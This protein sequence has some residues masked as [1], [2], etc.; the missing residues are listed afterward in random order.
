MVE[1]SGNNLMDASV[2]TAAESVKD[3]PKLPTGFGGAYKDITIDFEFNEPDKE[4]NPS[5]ASTNAPDGDA[6]D[7]QK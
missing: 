4:N 7:K 6:S 2:M 1:A 3:S 5:A